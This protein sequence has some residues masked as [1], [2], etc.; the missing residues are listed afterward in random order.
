MS[1]KAAEA[2][3]LG[4][5]MN[6]GFRV[7]ALLPELLARLLVSV[8]LIAVCSGVYLLFPFFEQSPSHLAY[9]ELAIFAWGILA[10]RLLIR[11]RR[12]SSQTWAHAEDARKAIRSPILASIS[13]WARPLLVVWFLFLIVFTT[14]GMVANDAGALG[15]GLFLVRDITILI[16][17]AG[18]GWVLGRLGLHKQRSDPSGDQSQ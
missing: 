7:L 2:V 12:D 13:T 8:V 11:R 14:Y 10:Y 6:P 15:D 5:S 3:R 17:G 9:L 4:G 18:L 1:T 16:L